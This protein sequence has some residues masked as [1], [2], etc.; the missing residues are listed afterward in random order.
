MKLFGSHNLGW[1]LSSLYLSAAAVGLF[2]LF[3]KTFVPRRVAL[4][5]AFFLAV[6]HY[7]MTFGKIGYN[8]LQALFAMSLALCAATWAIRTKRRIARARSSTYPADVDWR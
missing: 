8:N 2:Y 4:V 5:A 1:H 6:S 7:I 3:F